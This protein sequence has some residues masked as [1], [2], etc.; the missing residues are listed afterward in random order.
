MEVGDLVRVNLPTYSS[1]HGQLCI[2]TKLFADAPYQRD[3]LAA[4][5]FFMDGKEEPIYVSDLEV[6]NETR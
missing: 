6:V 4:Y 5:L 1:L 2:I 3:R